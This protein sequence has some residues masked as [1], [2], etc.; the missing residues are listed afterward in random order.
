MTH[1][2]NDTQ[3]LVGVLKGIEI[4]DKRERGGGNLNA[5]TIDLQVFFYKFISQIILTEQR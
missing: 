4:R 2:T 3:H 5:N 1:I